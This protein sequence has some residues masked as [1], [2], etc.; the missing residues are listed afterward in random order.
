MFEA[1]L[2]GLELNVTALDLSLLDNNIDSP[3][4]LDMISIRSRPHGVGEEKDVID[5]LS[6]IA[7]FSL[8]LIERDIPLNDPSQQQYSIG[9]SGTRRITKT[10]DWIVR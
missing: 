7:K 8:P 4:I 2:E 5:N 6:Q 9:Y 10:Y 3:D 1:R